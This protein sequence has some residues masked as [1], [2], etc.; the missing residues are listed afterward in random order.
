MKGSDSTLMVTNDSNKSIGRISREER[1]N[2]MFRQHTVV[3]ETELAS[4]MDIFDIAPS[5][6]VVIQRTV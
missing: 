3:V 5:E 4:T 2:S 1:D 6:V